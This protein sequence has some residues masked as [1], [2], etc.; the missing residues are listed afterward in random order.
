MSVSMDQADNNLEMV[1]SNLD[2]MSQNVSL[3]SSSL[4]QYKA[5]V[6]ESQ[7]SMDNLQTML[8]NIQSNLGMII[9][10]T[11]IVLALFFLW[12]LA[13]QVVIFSQG[14]ELFNGTAGRMEGSRSNPPEKDAASAN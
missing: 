5:M 1:K 9:N 8:F 4:S 7:A 10:G 14:W 2:I 6:G 12:L 11:T 13:T 3:I